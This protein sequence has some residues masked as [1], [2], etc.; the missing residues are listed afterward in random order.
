MLYDY[1][2][3]KYVDHLLHFLN[4][5]SFAFLSS[6]CT[7]L[8]GIV[9]LQ[10]FSTLIL[11]WNSLNTVESEHRWVIAPYKTDTELFCQ[12]TLLS[13]WTKSNQAENIHKYKTTTRMPDN[14]T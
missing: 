5:N 10:F 13:N 12:M 14:M 6:E 7:T 4:Y 8:F 1:T 3:F 2:I 11:Y 9:C